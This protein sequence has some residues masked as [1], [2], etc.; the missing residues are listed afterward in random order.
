MYCDVANTS[1]EQVYK[2][3]TPCLDDHQFTKE[4]SETAGE[5]S[6]KFTSRPEMLIFSTHIGRPD[7]LWSVS[8]LAGAITKLARLIPHI[9]FST[10]SRQYRHVE[11]NRIGVQGFFQDAAF[12]SDLGGLQIAVKKYVVHLGKQHICADWMVFKKSRQLFH[13][14]GLKQ[15]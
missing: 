11:D 2:V 13:T 1:I 4:E 3:S 10:G 7:I 15:R 14:A 5:L 6:N 9:H 8:Y 12:A